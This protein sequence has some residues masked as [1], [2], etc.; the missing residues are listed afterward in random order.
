VLG[1]GEALAALTVGFEVVA[2]AVVLLVLAMAAKTWLEP[3]L[4]STATRQ[5]GGILRILDIPG[6]AIRRV[7]ASAFSA[8]THSLSVAASHRMRPLARWIHAL[9]S[10]VLGSSWAVA[11]FAGDM[12]YSIERLATVVLPREI[13]QATR[14]I[15]RRA[16]RALAAAAAAALA[17][18]NLR[19][20]LNRLYGHTIRPALH[21]LTHAVDVAIPRA[22][23]GIRS[24]L[25]D[26]EHEIAHPSTRWLRRTATAMWGA[27]LLGLMIR[28]LA[29]RFPWLFCRQVKKVGG[30]I[31][32]LDAS[33]LDSLL[34]DAL[35]IASVISVKEFAHELQAIEHEALVILAAGI[36]ELPSP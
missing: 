18:R 9:G 26:V 5:G 8:V 4:S 11:H 16:T 1:G 29:R 23:G 32:G 15:S 31:C 36:D 13:G 2:I 25:R 17:A 28:T 27:A 30:R 14:P 10:L 19:H 34:L 21:H 24:R 33:L 20:Y 12:A 7:A 35:A 22:L 3:L 6:A